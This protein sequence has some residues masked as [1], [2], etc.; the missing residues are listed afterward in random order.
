MHKP[1]FS[2]TPCSHFNNQGFEEG[3]FRLHVPNLFRDTEK[4]LSEVGVEILPDRLFC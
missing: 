2:T 3:S 4:A 1:A